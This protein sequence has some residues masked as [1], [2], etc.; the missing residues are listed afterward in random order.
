MT[1]DERLHS[2]SDDDLLARLSILMRDSRQAEADLIAHVG[3]ADA[4]RLYAREATPSMFVYCVERLH[5]SEAEA[6]LRIT[7]ARASREHPMLL[8]MLADGR[9]HLSAIAELA[10][11]LT[12]ENRDDLLARAT[13]RSKREIKELLA[14][15]FP[16]PDVPAVMRKLPDRRETRRTAGT[17]SAD[18]NGGTL[19]RPLVGSDAASEP[20][21]RPDGVVNLRSVAPPARVEPLAP[22]RYKVQFTASTE[23]HDKLERLQALMRS[24]VPDGDLATII[25]R[26]VT[27]K[28]ERLEARRFAVTKTPRRTLAETETSSRSRH[29][30]AAVR[31]AVY[32]RDGN[33]C[34][35]VDVSGRQC[36]ARHNLEFHHRYP[37]GHG[38][39]HRPDDIGLLCPTHNRLLAEHDYGVEKMRKYAR[40][41]ARTVAPC[42]P[43][44]R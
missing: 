36:T 2:I 35:F 18:A 40:P 27:E 31:R 21:L 34:G 20:Q 32:K 9:L 38:G 25:D 8:T 30:P 22:A 3:E 39:D 11:R 7:A 29:V 16:G 24:Q 17:T 44:D 26:A 37:F 6:Y 13:H 14:E 42:R 12:A 10:P 1:H 23:L 33:R 19:P 4:R 28:L 41:A 5:L 15:M 43:D